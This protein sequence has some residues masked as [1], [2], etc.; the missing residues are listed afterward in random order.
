M[1]INLVLTTLLFLL[2]SNIICGSEEEENKNSN[3]ETENL[4]N[5]YVSDGHNDKIS[6]PAVKTVERREAGVLTDDND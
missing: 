1:R 2:P 5:I 4:P 6:G 3:L